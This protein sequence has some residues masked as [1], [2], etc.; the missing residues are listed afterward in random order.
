MKDVSHSVDCLTELAKSIQARTGKPAKAILEVLA[1]L[2][3][4][5]R[6]IEARNEADAVKYGW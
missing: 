1:E 2:D 5:G 3:A 4:R 6:E